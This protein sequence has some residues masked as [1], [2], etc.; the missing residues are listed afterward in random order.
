[1]DE[2][3]KNNTINFLSQIP[4]IV[5]LIHKIKVE[6]P[7]VFHVR[8][9]DYLANPTYHPQP[10]NEYYYNAMDMHNVHHIFYHTTHGCKFVVY[11]TKPYSADGIAFKRREEDAAK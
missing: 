9:G 4:E 6:S 10:P 3:K 1:V 5:A 8:R 7:V 11:P 2:F